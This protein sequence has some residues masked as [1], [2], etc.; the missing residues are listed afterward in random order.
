MLG[1][2]LLSVRQKTLSSSRETDLIDF[3]KIFFFVPM[4]IKVYLKLTG[5]EEVP[6]Q[7]KS[8]HHLCY[9]PP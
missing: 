8:L 1:K 5:N 6:T 2:S 4:K 9:A 7:Q 3:F